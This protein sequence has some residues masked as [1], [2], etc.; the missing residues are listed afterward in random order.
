[1]L[2]TFVAP[3]PRVMVAVD[4][5]GSMGDDELQRCLAECE[6]VLRAVGSD[7]Q[8]IT[9]DADVHTDTVMRT[10]RDA[11]RKM[12]GGGGTNF[13]PMF[14]R[15]MSKRP[16]P[17]VLIVL[18]DGGGPAPDEP[19]PGIRVVW[20]LCGAHKRHPYNATMRGHV[21]Y[22]DMIEIDD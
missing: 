1:V 15:A 12:T 8:F 16:R 21:T 11:A 18:T 6:G 10:W 13:I 2:P 3:V 7:L 14:E 22:G 4:T 19:P 20:V 5:S 17:E 9:C